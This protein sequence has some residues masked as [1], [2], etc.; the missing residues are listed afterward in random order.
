MKILYVSSVVCVPCVGAEG[1]GGS[2][3]TYEV[4]RHLA[5]LGHRVFVACKRCRQQ[6]KVEEKESIVFYRLFSWDGFV[7]QVVRRNTLTRRLAR[8]PYYTIRSLFHAWLLIRWATKH[9]IE[10]IYERSSQS[11][12]A[13]TLCSW[14]LG[15]P[16][17]L[18]V[19]DHSFQ[20]LAMKLCR[21]I[22]TP[23]VG[24]IPLPF[25]KKVLQMEWA[26]NTAAFHPDVEC[27]W[28]RRKY[29]VSKNI[30]ALFVGSGLPWHGLDDIVKAAQLLRKKELPIVFVIVG[31]GEQ[32]RALQK[33]VEQNGM[34]DSFR[35]AGAV[36]YE[37]I[38]A[39][40]AAA[41]I[42]LA[43][44]NSRLAKDNRHQTA[45]PMKLF[46]YMAC[47]KPVITTP[48][49]N[50]RGILTHGESAWI[51]SQDSPAA[52][53]DA[54]EKLASNAELRHSL[55]ENAR[56]AVV[57]MYSWTSHCANLQNLFLRVQIDSAT[58]SVSEN[59]TPIC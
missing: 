32:V 12:I 24:S 38:P 58:R 34:L 29:A 57:N 22:V 37:L 50:T 53:A 15:I 42:T 27:E 26:V 52:L 18:E 44:Y 6:L 10:L 9:G 45:S 30:L 11:T 49:V 21:A 25:R 3:H 28:V 54:V 35:F 19:N 13:A 41:D 20:P 7:Y 31:S 1:A 2:T 14:A 33:E 48:V 17:V 16:L 51:V 46:E 47:G 39:F 40:I 23:D 5:R 59:F 8:V 56:R 36:D 43:P 55:G 4:A